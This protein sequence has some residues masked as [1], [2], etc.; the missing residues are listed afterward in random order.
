MDVLFMLA[1]LI[2][3]ITTPTSGSN[4]VIK[5]NGMS[6]T[7]TWFHLSISLICHQRHLVEKKCSKLLMDQSKPLA[8]E[9][10]TFLFMKELIRMNVKSLKILKLR[11]LRILQRLRNKRLPKRLL[12]M[13]LMSLLKRLRNKRKN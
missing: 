8:M 2:K 9:M 10:L 3:V 4:K 12:L 1:Q 7:I 13:K 11:S 6:S 5:K